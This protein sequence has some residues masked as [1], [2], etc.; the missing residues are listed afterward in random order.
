MSLVMF[1]GARAGQTG[2]PFASLLYG[3]GLAATALVRAALLPFAFV[4]LAWFL[5]RS[6]T[7]PGGWLAALLAFLGFV[8]GVAPWTVRNW[9][10]F[11]EPVAIVDSAYVHLWMGNNPKADGGPVD[12]DMWRPGR[13]RKC[14]TTRS[15]RSATPASAASSGKRCS[16]PPA[17]PSTACNRAWPSSLA[18]AK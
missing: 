16:D 17:V 4:G 14:K 3:L 11:G 13:S 18:N 7:L 1:A 5:L 2:G 15:S 6:R 10:Q 8:I 9:Q 12:V